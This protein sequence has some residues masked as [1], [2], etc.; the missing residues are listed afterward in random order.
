M[1]A[2]S[3]SFSDF[4]HR[5]A[6]IARARNQVMK[7]FYHDPEYTDYPF[8]FFVDCDFFGG[9]HSDAVLTSFLRDD[10]DIACSNGEDTIPLPSPPLQSHVDSIK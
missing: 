6:C 2:V 3:D 9:F 1:R 10:W 8:F 4:C 7:L 5:E